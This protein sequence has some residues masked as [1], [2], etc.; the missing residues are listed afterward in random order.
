[1]VDGFGYEVDQTKIPCMDM[2]R[3]LGG[4]LLVAEYEVP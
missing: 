1:M 3:P 2:G 4:G